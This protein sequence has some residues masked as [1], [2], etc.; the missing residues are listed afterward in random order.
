MTSPSSRLGY[1]ASI[2]ANVVF[3]ALAILYFIRREAV[4]REA[5]RREAIMYAQRAS[6]F[7]SLPPVR[8][9]T[10]F[11]G[12]SLTAG[13]EW[14]EMFG[15]PT[16]M[17]RGI[18]G[19]T[20]RGVL[21]R[22]DPITAGA[23]AKVF[24]MIGTNDLFRGAEIQGGRRIE[25]FDHGRVIISS[26][27]VVPDTEDQQYIHWQRCLGAKNHVSSYGE[28]GDGLDGRLPGMGPPGEEV[29]TFADEAV[30]F[31]EISYDYQSLVGETFGFTDEVTATASFTVRDDRDLTQ[32]YQRDPSDPDP[33]AEC[34]AFD[35]AGRMV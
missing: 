24:L 4:T 18:P 25:L 16:L 22:L 32:I 34:D 28:E 29:R 20:T 2:G 9:G 7:E 12:D 21:A 15:D 11:L 35:N 1:R 30:I 5:E 23:P 8:R 27:E 31:V 13:G 17:N 10:V 6:R 33:V 19:E 26:L 14:A 3:V